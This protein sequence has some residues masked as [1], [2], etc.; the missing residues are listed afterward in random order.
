MSPASHPVHATLQCFRTLDPQCQHFAWTISPAVDHHNNM[1]KVVKNT[2]LNHSMLQHTMPSA[3]C[4]SL[5]VTLTD[6]SIIQLAWVKAFFAHTHPFRLL[7]EGHT[8][9]E[10]SLGIA[11]EFSVWYIKIY[12]CRAV[13][14][15]LRTHSLQTSKM[16][17]F[18][19]SRSGRVP[20]NCI[21]TQTWSARGS[22]QAAS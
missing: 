9:T 18:P 1:V 12:T 6:T 2:P 19:W 7:I 8:L 22:V 16:G 4:F 10:S 15:Y 21:C 17:F 20:W 11:P 3:P 5:P 14:S 13:N